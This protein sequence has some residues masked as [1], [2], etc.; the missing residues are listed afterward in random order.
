MSLQDVKVEKTTKAGSIV[1]VVNGVAVDADQ[2]L[3]VIKGAK[4]IDH[5]EVKALQNGKREIVGGYVSY[6]CV[7]VDSSLVPTP[8]AKV[9]KTNE[10]EKAD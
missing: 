9:E 4:S 5:T 10:S 8:P 3:A 1:H 2:Y 7:G 6:T